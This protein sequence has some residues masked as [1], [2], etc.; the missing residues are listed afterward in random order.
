MSRP[1]SLAILGA[2]L[3]GLSLAEALIQHGFSPA[4]LLIADP[5]MPGAGAS[6][7]PGA[8]VHPLPGRS[9]R[10]KPGYGEA[11]AFTCAWLNALPAPLWRT[12]QVLR[13]AP[14]SEG[15]E[16]MAQSLTQARR[17]AP[18][19]PLLNQVQTLDAEAVQ[20][21]WP[22]LGAEQAFAVPARTVHLKQLISH[23]SSR[24]QQQGATFITPEQLTITA[25]RG[26]WT[27]T[28][29]QSSESV[30]QLVLTPGIALKKWFPH[31][32]LSQ[33]HG[34]VQILTQP[35]WNGVEV[36]ISGSG[37]LAP[38]PDGTWVAG[39][40]FYRADQP[41][42][43]EEARAWINHRLGHL[44]PSWDSAQE[45][46][47]WHGQRTV[48]APDREPVAGAVPGYTNLWVL[49]GLAARGLLWGPLLANYLAQTLMGQVVNWPE[50]V[51]PERLPPQSWVL[52]SIGW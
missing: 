6:G 32:H 47:L 8:L 26:G 1:S 24:L 27:L 37:H 52:E 43:A 48:I 50:A 2:G 42:S 21:L 23:L 45:Q 39:A 16:R 22:G 36:A 12:T 5:V 34:E 9:L 25:E 29:P 41:G 19:H 33:V 3:A 13:L 35:A 7:I 10:P 51:R 30:A 18:D 31:L 11:F 49:S 4:N 28:T 40:T 46:L 20:A 14:N 38:L 15:R 44:A 17:E